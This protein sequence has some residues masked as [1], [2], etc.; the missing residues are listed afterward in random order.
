MARRTDYFVKSLG[1]GFKV[2]KA[3][4]PERPELTLTEVADIVG[5]D[6]ATTR[7]FLYTLED[8][9]L[10]EKNARKY[11]RL[12]PK[13]LELAYTYISSLHYPDIALPYMEE[14]RE[15]FNESVNLGVL[16]GKEIVY[17]VRV[18]AKRIVGMN[19]RVGTRLPAHVTSMGKIILAHKPFRTVKALLGGK[20]EKFTDKTITDF[21]KFREELNITKERGYSVNNEELEQGLISIA[22]PIK[23]Y[24]G[25]VIAALNI[26]SSTSRHTI[27][28]MVKE[29]LPELNKVA[30]TVSR[31]LG[32]RG[33]W[34]K[35]G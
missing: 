19:I 23:D 20:L 31:Q 13:I 3:F 11:F 8:L 25:D 10:L 32:Y 9:G 4:T 14:L 17:V 29:F 34:K 27:D 12:S 30:E 6:R 22:V 35:I 33:E 5:F 15:K 28:S 7:R 2:L 26:A 21:E 24:T 16:D 18:P 1:K